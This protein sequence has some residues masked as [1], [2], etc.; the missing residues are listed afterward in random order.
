MSIWTTQTE[1]WDRTENFGL[2]GLAK[3]SKLQH[4]VTSGHFEPCTS[5]RYQNERMGQL[6][7]VEWDTLRSFSLEC[8]FLKT[9]LRIQ[10]KMTANVSH[11]RCHSKLRLAHICAQFDTYLPCRAQSGRK[12]QHVEVSTILPTPKVRNFRFGPTVWYVQFG[13]AWELHNL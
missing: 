7:S 1:P 9:K 12:L 13:S 11:G 2:S 5:S 6:N 4:A 10:T 3:W 8:A